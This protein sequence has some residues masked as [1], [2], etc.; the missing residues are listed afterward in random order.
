ME[1]F[2]SCK[3]FS[4]SDFG[5]AF[6]VQSSSAAVFVS[7]FDLIGT[8]GLNQW[9]QNSGSL[10]RHHHHG[11]TFTAHQSS[12]IRYHNVK[13]SGTLPPVPRKMDTRGR[14]ESRLSKET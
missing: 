6:V 10:T 14:R 1:T 8:L 12:L 4:Q 13:T 11:G 5:L 9:I 7:Y 2:A 3:L